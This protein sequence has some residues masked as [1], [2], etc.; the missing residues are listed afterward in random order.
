MP[1]TIHSIV[2]VVEDLI[3][4]YETS[5]V[6]REENNDKKAKFIIRDDIVE[7]FDAE[8]RLIKS[9]VYLIQ[10]EKKGTSVKIVEFRRSL[11]IMIFEA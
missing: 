6:V 5:L 7:F 10:N 3:Y 2:F 8:R 4:T 9:L 1:Y 11:W